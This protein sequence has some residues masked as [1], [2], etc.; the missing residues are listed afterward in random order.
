MYKGSGEGGKKTPSFW[1][2]GPTTKTWMKMKTNHRCLTLD[3][4]N[5]DRTFLI[6]GLWKHTLEGLYVPKTANAKKNTDLQSM[7][8]TKG[9]TQKNRQGLA[10][11]H[12]FYSLSSSNTDKRDQENLCT[13]FSKDS[14][15]TTWRRVKTYRLTFNIISWI[16]KH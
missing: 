13:T 9:E 11:L 6:F 10:L 14:G 7:K 16:K 1:S 8:A 2:Q 15:N 5:T 12:H 3:V 4:D